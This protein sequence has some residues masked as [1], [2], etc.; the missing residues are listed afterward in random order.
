MK[1]LIIIILN[2]DIPII[3][4]R[5]KIC[6]SKWKLKFMVSCLV[7][8]LDKFCEESSL[9][10]IILGHCKTIEYCVNCL[11]TWISVP[12]LCS[13]NCAVFLT[14]APFLKSING[15]LPFLKVCKC[16]VNGAGIV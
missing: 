2:I 5:E 4:E 11:C 15:L 13:Q 10:K 3:S 1:L 7:L 8:D 16:Q 6:Y 12:V 14:L 9:E